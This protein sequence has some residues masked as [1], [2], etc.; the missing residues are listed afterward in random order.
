M[1]ATLHRL[2][3]LLS[4]CADDYGLSSGISEGIAE[5]AQARR[6]TAVSCISNAPYWHQ[7][8]ARLQEFPDTV[9]VG[10]HFNLTEGMPLSR[11]LAAVWPT[12]PSLPTLILRAH[13]GLI[14]LHALACEFTAQWTSFTRAT[15]R[16]PTFMDGHQ[17][18]HHLPGVRT[19]V[20]NALDTLQVRPAIRNTAR[21]AGPGFALKRWVIRHTGGRRLEAELQRRALPHNSC[22]L[23]TYD[24]TGTDYRSRMQA[25]LGA[26]PTAG[27]LIYC[28]PGREQ[29]GDGKDPVAAARVHERAYLSSAAFQQDLADA[30][31]TLVRDWQ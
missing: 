27:G 2:P 26:L 13:L 14:P 4:I 20:F 25:W 19:A 5:L 31:V 9:A 1:R 15:G 23:G 6:I 3:R 18:V 16:Q 30:N 24:F 29:N 10:L 7:A 11:E 21:S 22:L 12:L 8:S 17:H 28:H